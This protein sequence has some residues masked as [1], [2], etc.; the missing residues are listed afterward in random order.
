[1]TTNASVESLFRSARVDT[2]YIYKGRTRV[3]P[4]ESFQSSRDE[5]LA[6][7][8]TLEVSKEQT[9]LDYDNNNFLPQFIGPRDVHKREVIDV[10]KKEGGD[11]FSINIEN[12][13]TLGESASTLSSNLETIS[14]R[15]E[16][17]AKNFK[18][19]PHEMVVLSLT[20]KFYESDVKLENKLPFVGDGLGRFSPDYVEVREKEKEIWVLELKTRMRD[21]D[22][23]DAFEKAILKYKV[24][25]EN[26]SHK[27]P[28]RY[29]VMVVTPLR[30]LTNFPMDL[31]PGL[32]RAIFSH[33]HF[34]RVLLNMAKRLGLPEF[35]SKEMI[36]IKEEIWNSIKLS[37]DKTKVPEWAE[38]PIVSQLMIDVWD[39][40]KPTEQDKMKFFRHIYGK[41]KKEFEHRDA[42]TDTDTIIND[43]IRTYIKSWSKNGSR[44]DHKA[45]VQLPFLTP[46]TT[47]ITN[48]AKK[49]PPVADLHGNAM[50]RVWAS[51]VI[52]ARSHPERFQDSPIEKLIEKAMMTPEEYKAFK[53]PS[54]RRNW[55]RA[56]I[57]ITNLDRIEFAQ[58]GFQARKLKENKKVEEAKLKQKE[59]FARDVDNSDIDLFLEEI[60]DMLEEKSSSMTYL[61][62][63]NVDDLYRKAKSVFKT[64]VSE[65]RQFVSEFSQTKIGATLGLWNTIF[66]EL[67]LSLSQFCDT[68]EV[69]LKQMPFEGLYIIVK[70]SRP[71]RQ[72]CFTLLADKKLYDCHGLPFKNPEF[73]TDKYWCFDFMGFNRHKMSHYLFTFESICLLFAMWSQLSRVKP[74]DVLRNP[75]AHSQVVKHFAASFLIYMEDKPQTSESLQLIRYAYMEATKKSLL[76]VEP[77]KIMK[78]MTDRPKSRLLVWIINR[79]LKV[80]SIMTK[81]PPRPKAPSEKEIKN[82]IGVELESDPEF[83]DLFTDIRL[84]ISGD[85]FQDLLSWVDGTEIKNFEIAL[86]LSYLGSLHNRDE[87]DPLQGFLKIFQKVIKEELEM[88]NSRRTMMGME[89]DPNLKYGD[90]EFDYKFVTH[91]GEQTKGYLQRKYANS[92]DD[93]LRERLTQEML[94]RTAEYFST[95]KASAIPQGDAEYKEQAKP[96]SHRR[97]ALEGVVDLLRDQ[98]WTD[99][100]PII[101]QH[102]YTR[103][104]AILDVVETQGGVNANLFEKPQIGGVRE[105][106]VLDISSRLAIHFVESISRIICEELPME[107]L[108]KGD[109]KIMKSDAHYNRVAAAKKP[110]DKTTTIIDSDDAT[111]WCQRFVMSLFACL[112]RPLIPKD[113]Y[114][115]VVRVLNLVSRKKLELPYLLLHQFIIKPEI[116]NYDP[117]MVEL[118][119]QFLGL[120]QSHDLINSPL[121]IFLNNVSNM[122]QG[123]LHYTSSLL[124]ASYILSMSA[125]N[126]SFVMA[127]KGHGLLPQNVR[128]IQTSKCSSDDSSVIRTMIYEGVDSYIVAFVLTI[129]SL[130]KKNGY[131]LCDVEQSKPK[132]TSESFS[133]IEEFNSIWHVSNNLMT[134]LVKFVYAATKLKV[135]S[136]LDSRQMLMA[137]LRKSLTENGGDLHLSAI[138]QELHC[139]IHYATLGCN[140]NPLFEAYSELLL[141]R[142]HPALGFFVFEPES[143]SG[144]MGYDFSHYIA[145]KRLSGCSEIENWLITKEGAEL[146][147]FGK[148]TVTT[149]L[150]I[151]GGKNYSEFLK[152]LRAPENWRDQLTKSNPPYSLLFRPSYTPEESLFQ[153][154]KKA[155]TPSSS[156]AFS[157]QAGSK[158]HVSSVYILNTPS[159]LVSEKRLKEEGER[160]KK[161]LYAFAKEVP[162]TF[163][164]LNEKML[165]LLFPT[166]ELYDLILSEV[167]SINIYLSRKLDYSRPNRYVSLTMP[168]VPQVASVSLLDVVK[169]M[170]F[171]MDTPGGVTEHTIAF[172]EYRHIFPWLR[173]TLELTLEASPFRD[174]I[175][176]AEFIRA[177]LPSVRHYKILGPVKKGLPFAS[178]VKSIMRNCQHKGYVLWKPESDKPMSSQTVKEIGSKIL[179]LASSPSLTNE[180][181]TDK[182]KAL[183]SIIPKILPDSLIAA[184]T[185]LLSMP[186]NDAAL[187][188]IQSSYIGQHRLHQLLRFAKRGKV[189]YFTQ[190]Q[191]RDEN[192]NYVG[193]GYVT[194]EID[195]NPFTL[196][197]EG[198][199]LTKIEIKDLDRL[200]KISRVDFF[201]MI[202]EMGFTGE[203]I[204]NYIS[205]NWFYSNSGT[206]GDEAKK[207]AV[208]IKENPRM[209]AASLEGILKQFRLKDDFYLEVGERGNLKITL[210][211]Q[212]RQPMTIISFEAPIWR[213]N[214]NYAITSKEWLYITSEIKEIERS[215]FNRQRKG[216]KYRES[217]DNDDN[218][219]EQSSYDGTIEGT[220]VQFKP[221]A[222]RELLSK[223]FSIK[224]FF[225]KYEDIDFKRFQDE[226]GDQEYLLWFK[227]T[228]PYLK[229]EHVMKMLTLKRWLRVT[230]EEKA[231]YL[232][233]VPMRLFS[234]PGYEEDLEILELDDE[235]RDWDPIEDAGFE[236]AVD[237]VVVEEGT[238][239]ELFDEKFNGF[240]VNG[241]DR[242]KTLFADQS[243]LQEMTEKAP[244]KINS[245][246]ESIFSLHPFWMKFINALLTVER[247]LANELL[248]GQYQTS[249]PKS[250]IGSLTHWLMEVSL[251][252][253][254]RPEIKPVLIEDIDKI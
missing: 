172:Q 54:E 240:L 142:P 218:N 100:K 181:R 129:M 48:D 21:D 46:K 82:E 120:S 8:M 10:V 205:A 25:L 27:M 185:E 154:Y 163:S 164:R 79:V 221:M 124:H 36:N 236:A 94:N 137:D 189:A 173:V 104:H 83:A 238:E 127:L 242:L 35:L 80:F 155:Y 215:R 253:E 2:A 182:I 230:L 187:A 195:D 193:R 212:D 41:S 109:Q 188:V 234:D 162:T 248:L 220:W 206:F 156:E 213:F 190:P 246:L 237:R 87:R 134:P 157:F 223:L 197:L 11:V 231:K 74:I 132:S 30:I 174:A 16:I 22:A 108:T 39:L 103:L 117:G 67:N 26:R 122:M 7:D 251:R 57:E 9:E 102:P 85:V 199:V 160:H 171:G 252:P 88:R 116:F 204:F 14:L 158:L 239:D 228:Y 23:E 166:S 45:P 113:L 78:K 60:F 52:S 68:D 121:S 144:V 243:E 140:T 17:E 203:N 244:T 176:L 165:D 62:K 86:N 98:T 207:Y 225:D 229:V 146:S 241:L 150:M 249:L 219:N 112:L 136:R 77:L 159:V 66:E 50:M 61:S 133:A 107:M 145:I 149:T 96:E 73:S 91:L 44:R 59:A 111:T 38:P 20:G 232:N 37:N 167:D 64:D 58:K 184:Q 15:A 139:Y 175:S 49:L 28:I 76:P 105:I 247:S 31:F 226:K 81:I 55:H 29:N 128:L 110:N 179:L 135:I 97:K 141:E 92:F 147:E 106:F 250:D 152:R 216:Q 89:T 53:V 12:V 198:S 123:I 63:V 191:K 183:L 33:Y 90:H 119:K 194:G 101:N 51:A 208:P 170:W 148:P 125:M 153:I 118:K 138:C 126:K 32:Q 177:Q 192:G 99:G 233:L 56:D 84:N 143:F 72:A 224:H 227:R 5:R 196:E 115:I 24:A 34:G 47:L 235:W 114:M 168:K 65:A 95:F 130:A 209:Q 43:Q 211:L 245:R 40:N 214:S 1:M 4:H 180:Q 19:I 18:K 42:N 71:D 75:R 217:E 6:E 200:K 161:S 201:R 254:R 69:V 202:K 93:H 151:G 169:R 178:A 70:P 186:K 222:E 3:F 13:M 131:H 210:S